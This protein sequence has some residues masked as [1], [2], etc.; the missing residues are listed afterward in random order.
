MTREVNWIDPTTTL[1]EAARRMRDG[2]VGLL[3]VGENDRLIGMLTDR[4]IVVRAV[5]EQEDAGT[6]TARD[7]MSA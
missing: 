6:A 7:A 4:D 3:P 5:A 1:V 2:D